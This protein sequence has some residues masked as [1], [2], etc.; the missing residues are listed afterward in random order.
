M[1][2]VSSVNSHNSNGISF[3]EIIW[4]YSLNFHTLASPSS[5]VDSRRPAVCGHQETVFTSCEW[6]RC[7]AKTN[8]KFGWF[9]S[10]SSDSL[11]I[12]IMSSP[13]AVAIKP[14]QNDVVSNGSQYY[15]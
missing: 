4:N 8:S 10:V 13:Q 9:L 12:L 3:G 14:I 15:S 2:L 1:F 7:S 11:N 6:A 5:L